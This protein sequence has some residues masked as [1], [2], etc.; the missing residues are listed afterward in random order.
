MIERKGNTATGND[1][2]ATTKDTTAAR[3]AP[4]GDRDDTAS[5]VRARMDSIIQE[6][7]PQKKPYASIFVV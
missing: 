2:Q 1:E 7:Y 6:P 4:P 5:V 3:W